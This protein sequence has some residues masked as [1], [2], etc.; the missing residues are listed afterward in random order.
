M[1][2]NAFWCRLDVLAKMVGC[3]EWFLI[4]RLMEHPSEVYKDGASIYL[5]ET[6]VELLRS[7]YNL[8]QDKKIIEALLDKAERLQ[9]FIDSN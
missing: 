6:T 7:L 2:N 8:K 4:E 3:D 9:Q 1:G 5:N